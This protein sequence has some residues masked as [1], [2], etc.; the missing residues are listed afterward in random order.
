MHFLNSLALCVS[1]LACLAQ[2]SAAPADG[3]ETI[4]RG[5]D[6]DKRDEPPLQFN[7]DPDIKTST[8]CGSLF[9]SNINVKFSPNLIF[10]SGACDSIRNFIGGNKAS[11]DVEVIFLCP[12]SGPDTV[13]HR[14]TKFLIA[15]DYS[16][17]VDMNKKGEQKIPGT[18]HVV[19]THAGYN[20]QADIHLGGIADKK[21]NEIK[22]QFIYCVSHVL[23]L[24]VF[25][26]K[27]TPDSEIGANA[28]VTTTILQQ[29]E[30][31][32]TFH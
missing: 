27:L 9:Y 16:V 6:V 13:G 1:G 18:L 22:Y 21:K 7:I 20:V 24:A 15:L 10:T 5:N 14:D 26:K 28:H 2:V 4:V 11:L 31:V 12:N 29:R 25:D 19:D 32:V 8:G 23:S 30:K 17:P 3:F